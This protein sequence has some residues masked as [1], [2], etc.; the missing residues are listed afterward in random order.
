MDDFEFSQ[1]PDFSEL[2]P[3][4]DNELFDQSITE[5]KDGLIECPFLPLRDVVLFPQMVM[6]LFV[7]RE[8]SLAAINAANRNHEN[9]IVAAQRDDKPGDPEEESIFSIGT[10]TSI[11]RVLRMPDEST[12]VLAQG[13]RRVEILEFTQLTPYIRARARV[14]TQVVHL[15]LT[16]VREN[17]VGRRD[18]LELLMGAGVRV[19]IRVQLPCQL[20]VRTLD[21]PGRGVAG[22]PEG[23]VIIGCHRL[24]HWLRIR[25]R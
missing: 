10:E 7:G 5:E 21:L 13:R 16:R 24:P 17:L 14:M 4:L 2:F 23:L 15:A 3:D 18:V 6:P 20:P 25:P 8:R 1:F 11:G 9:L 19:H 22:H 12:S